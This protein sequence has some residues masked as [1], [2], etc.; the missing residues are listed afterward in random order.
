MTPVPAPA[1]AS[2]LVDVPTY[3]EAENVRAAAAAVLRAVPT[4][5]VLVVDDGSPDGT[6]GG[7]RDTAS[8]DPRWHLFERSGNRDLG[9]CR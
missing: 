1:P 8:T 7:V 4:A 5:H 9:T 2:A 6:A 3:D